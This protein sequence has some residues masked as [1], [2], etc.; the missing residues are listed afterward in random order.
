M[1]LAFRVDR[2]PVSFD[3]LATPLTKGLWS[4]AIDHLVIDTK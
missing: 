1:E 2:C 3:Y 4:N